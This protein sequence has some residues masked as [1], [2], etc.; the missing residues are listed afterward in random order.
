M[1]AGSL[2]GTAAL[3]VLAASVSGS[4]AAASAAGLAA[5]AA[6]AAAV[7]MT[8]T[9]LLQARREAARD[10]ARLAAECR[11]LETRRAVEHRTAL[12][13]AARREAAMETELLRARAAAEEADSQAAAALVTVAELE[14]EV[15]DLRAALAAQGDGWLT[16][17][18]TRRELRPA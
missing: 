2:L 17:A 6:G 3:L 7:R 5:V 14:V 9:E 1:G 13:H 15:V 11:D 12:A 4:V 18:P 10:R 8:R 16:A